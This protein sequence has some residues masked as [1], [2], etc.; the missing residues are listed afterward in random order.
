MEQTKISVIIPVHNGEKTLEQ[1][2]NSVA[3][4]TY[5]NYEIIAVDNNS[6]D[7]TKK[8]IEDFSKGNENVKYVFE[9]KRGRGAARNAGVKA[10]S[11]EIIAM[12]DSDCIAPENWIE[13]LTK[14]I[15]Y[16]NESCSRGFQTD[17]IKNYWTKNIQ[18]ADSEFINLASDGIYINNI[19]TKNFAIRSS[20][21]KKYKFDTNLFS[22]DDL[23]LFLRLRENNIRVR[24]LPLV[25]V[26]HNHQASLRALIKSNFERAYWTMKIYKKHKNNPIKDKEMLFKSISLKNFI[27][28]P[29]WMM[30]Q[31]IK[32]PAGEVFFIFVSEISWYTGLICAKIK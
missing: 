3:G 4:Q 8:I 23:D 2:L 30:L 9:K 14:P 26:G 16:E 7:N 24:F 17:L 13:E 18:R 12:I 29:F 11:G 19:D 28:F 6:T 31:F 1:C 21:M 5:Q 20:L 32:R 22:F 25:N 15:I 10:A 27:L